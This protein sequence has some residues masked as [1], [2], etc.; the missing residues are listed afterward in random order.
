MSHGDH[1]SKIP[2]NWSVIAKSQDGIIAAVEGPNIIAHQFIPKLHILR[3]APPICI[4]FFFKHVKH[5][6]IGLLMMLWKE[7]YERFV[8]WSAINL[9]ICVLRVEVLTLR[10][11]Q[12]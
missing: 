6:K 12:P 9:C 5:L 3:M 11:L 10:W 7:K 4:I 2:D 8:V 1:I